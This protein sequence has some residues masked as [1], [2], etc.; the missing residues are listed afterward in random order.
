MHVQIYVPPQVVVPRSKDSCRPDRI[1]CAFQ[2]CTNAALRLTAIF[3]IP[4]SVREAVV[5]LINGAES[6]Q[7]ITGCHCG[8]ISPWALAKGWST[9]QQGQVHSGEE[10]LTNSTALTS[11]VALWWWYFQVVVLLFCRL[12]FGNGQAK[13]YSIP[14]GNS[15]WGAVWLTIELQHQHPY[16]GIH[17]LPD[18]WPLFLLVVIFLTGVGGLSPDHQ[19]SVA[20]SYKSIILRF[21]FPRSQF[22]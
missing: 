14:A 19:E 20:G 5:V 10:A 16:I 9:L 13:P 1:Y 8:P 3:S 12:Y 21:A 4:C 7:P 17:P 2:L 18:Y 22:Y 15:P 6:T 11:L